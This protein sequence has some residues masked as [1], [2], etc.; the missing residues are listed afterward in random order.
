MLLP[1]LAPLSANGVS[2]ITGNQ[3]EN[4]SARLLIRVPLWAKS[5]EHLLKQHVPGRVFR[6]YLGYRR[7]RTLPFSRPEFILLGVLKF[8]TARKLA[9]LQR[10]ILAQC[11]DKDAIMHQAASCNK[12]QNQARKNGNPDAHMTPNDPSSLSRHSGVCTTAEATQHPL[13][14]VDLLFCMQS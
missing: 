14:A 8:P 9:H 7:S 1:I 10:D 5:G 2:A 13:G 12:S 4:L 11:A 3:I 6:G